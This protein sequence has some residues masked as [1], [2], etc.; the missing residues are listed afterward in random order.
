M[1]PITVDSNLSQPYPTTPFILKYLLNNLFKFLFKVMQPSHYRSCPTTLP[2]LSYHMPNIHKCNWSVRT[3]SF[4][5]FV[6]SISS[7]WGA[8][9]TSHTTSQRWSIYV[10]ETRAIYSSHN[11]HH[12]EG[13]GVFMAAL[14]AAEPA[15]SAHTSL[16]SWMGPRL[17]LRLIEHHHCPFFLT[18]IINS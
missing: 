11:P 4:P 5:P 12:L 2:F 8:E 1:D 3:T 7:S 6:Q 15:L 16:A 10:Y 18:H 9:L 17:Q 13:F 14:H